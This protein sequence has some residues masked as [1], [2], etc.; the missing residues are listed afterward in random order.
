MRDGVD[1]Y[2]GFPSTEILEKVIEIPIIIKL[3]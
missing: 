1:V 2:G 3:Y